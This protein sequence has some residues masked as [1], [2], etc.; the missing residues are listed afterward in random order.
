MR[1][2]E[3][4]GPAAS[5]LSLTTNQSTAYAGRPF[6]AEGLLTHDGVGIA[7]VSLSVTARQ[8]GGEPVALP[9]VTTAADGSFRFRVAPPSPGSWTVTVGW[10][11]DGARP[12][13]SAT[14]AVT[15]LPVL[16]TVEL[17]V[18]VLRTGAVAGTV[19]LRSD[20][21]TLVAGRQVEVQV[22][23]QDGVLMTAAD[24]VTDASGVATFTHAPGVGTH[25]YT[26]ILWTDG[27]DESRSEKT[28][29]VA[30]VTPRH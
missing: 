2:L 11:G 27:L 10:A 3:A 25:T 22:L 9:A 8:Q 19:R 12:A 1:V 20:D 13:A 21:A 29:T 24:V 4:D 28:V 17:D 5:S 23:P 30:T 26:A 18:T 6:E 16:S 15:V 7:G 14:A